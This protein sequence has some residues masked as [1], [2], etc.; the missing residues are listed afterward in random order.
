MSRSANQQKLPTDTK[1]THTHTARDAASVIGVVVRS[2]PLCMFCCCCC[3]F[4]LLLFPS[5]LFRLSPF[6]S[7]SSE[8]T[9]SWPSTSAGPIGRNK[10][11]NNNNIKQQSNTN[12]QGEATHAHTIV[13][14]V[15]LL[16]SGFPCCP[17]CLVSVSCNVTSSTC[18]GR[19][20]RG[21]ANSITDH[22]TPSDDEHSQHAEHKTGGNNNKDNQHHQRRRQPGT[23]GVNVGKK[24]V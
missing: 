6:P 4:S 16:V 24:G 15:F 8:L 2:M 10:T 21:D 13:S 7:V 1:H 14:C 5:L 3:F 23:Q 20:Q 18:S 9:V 19:G 11:H 12:T 22:R 17:A